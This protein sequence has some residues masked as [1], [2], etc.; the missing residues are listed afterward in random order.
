MS[1]GRSGHAFCRVVAGV[2][3]ALGFVLLTA[4]PA[5]AHGVG[6]LEPTNYE[7]RVDGIRPATLGLEARPVDL[8]DR[9][10]LRNDTDRNVTVL[11]YEGEPYLRI[12]PDGTWQ[13]SRSPAVFL[14]RLRIPERAAPHGRY[15]A[16]AP[17]DW[18]KVSDEPLAAWHDHRAHFMGREDPPAVQAARGTAH[19]VIRDW[20]IPLVYEGKRLTITGDA[21][22]IPG[23][24]P[25]PWVLAAGGLALAVAVLCRTP[26]WATVMELALIVLVVSESVHVVGAWQATTVSL[27]S[28]ALASIYSLGGIVVSA[29]ALVWLRRQDPWAATPAVLVAGLF[30]F[31]AGGLADITTLTRSQLPTSLPVGL[32]RLTVTIALGLGAGLV[33]GAAGRLRAPP[34]MAPPESAPL[35][36][37]LVR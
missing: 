21:R 24:S 8:S 7:T 20:R 11:G 9:I 35:V 23:P 37:T 2:G 19:F 16:D 18:R 3:L 29:L 15:D 17:P 30:V 1:A 27:G 14:N 6:G 31:V 33:I 12:G 36:P 13:N 25:W 5:A 32:G 22:W 10:E 4:A 34:R 28:R 26:L